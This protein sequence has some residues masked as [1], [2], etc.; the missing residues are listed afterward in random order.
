MSKQTK[1]NPRIELKKFLANEKEITE[2]FDISLKE[3]NDFDQAKVRS[4]YFSNILA[5][6]V[7][8][9][10]KKLKFKHNSKK[11]FFWL[12][13]IILFIGTI[14]IPCLIYNLIT[15]TNFEQLDTTSEFLSIVIPAFVTLISTYL[16]TI[17]IIPKR[18]GEYLF[19]SEEDKSMHDFI[20]TIVEHDS[21]VKNKSN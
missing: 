5:I 8:D 9:I 18:I 4:K 10:E 2:D 1:D 20:K 13:I 15:N 19:D 17:W 21:N 16:A 14:L 6:Y 12:S 7:D 11:I 3:W